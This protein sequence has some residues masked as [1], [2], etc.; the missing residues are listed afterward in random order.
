[1]SFAF[2]NKQ[3]SC[4]KSSHDYKYLAVGCMDG[5]IIVY[6]PKWSD[7]Q[8]EIFEIFNHHSFKITDMV[9]IRGNYGENY[10]KSEYANED[11]IDY[12]IASVSWDR[13]LIISSLKQRLRVVN[14]DIQNYL[15]QIKIHEP[16][17]KLFIRTFEYQI[18]EVDMNVKLFDDQQ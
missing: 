2:L 1:M 13:R 4:L 3:V 16:S 5:S 11:T 6:Q 18:F 17:N 12:L 7:K 15:Q 14:Y 8:H 10:V 9:F